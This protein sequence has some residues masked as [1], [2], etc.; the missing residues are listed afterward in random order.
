VHRGGSDTA[1]EI[2]AHA[3]I[4]EADAAGR[5][6]GLA[7]VPIG[8]RDVNEMEAAISKISSDDSKQWS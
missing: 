1:D 6:L 4:A 5:R 7:V 2:G 8:A 3:Y